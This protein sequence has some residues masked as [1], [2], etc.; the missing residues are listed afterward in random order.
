MRQQKQLFVERLREA[1]RWS[2]SSGEAIPFKFVDLPRLF[3]A[4][5]FVLRVEDGSNRDEIG[6][7]RTVSP[8][9]RTKGL[10]RVLA[11]V[12]SAAETT[13]EQI[14]DRLVN[15]TAL[16]A[17][18][19]EPDDVVWLLL[20]DFNGNVLL[21]S[22][23]PYPAKLGESPSTDSNEGLNHPTLSHH[24]N[25][26]LH[27]MFGTQKIVRFVR[28]SSDDTGDFLPFDD[29]FDDDDDVID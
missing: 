18:S 9:L 29:D 10:M 12:S 19:S 2:D 22:C 4:A 17:S 5:C 6:E 23:W 28:A 7:I 20:G 8:Q 11:F 25:Q 21:Q 13:T 27:N 1:F 26:V 16:K 3:S 15:P 24:I 14:R